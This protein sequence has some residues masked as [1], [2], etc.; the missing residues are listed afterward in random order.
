MRAPESNLHTALIGV[1]NAAAISI[2]SPP[3]S[4]PAS[5]A[6]TLRLSRASSHRTSDKKETLNTATAKTIDA[7]Q[8]SVGRG[9]DRFSGV[10]WIWRWEDSGETWRWWWETA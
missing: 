7:V 5:R 9:R 10:H 6:K 4:L 2:N 1:F 8:N 3:E